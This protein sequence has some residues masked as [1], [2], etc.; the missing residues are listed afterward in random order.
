M[1][2]PPP[3]CSLKDGRAGRVLVELSLIEGWVQV[4]GVDNT[5]EGEEGDDVDDDDEPVD[6]PPATPVAAPDPLEWSLFDEDVP[7]SLTKLHAL[8]MQKDSKFLAAFYVA[9]NYTNTAVTHWDEDDRREVT[10]LMPKSAIVKANN[11]SEKWHYVVKSPGAGFILH[12]EVNHS[13]LAVDQ[14]LS[15]NYLLLL[16]LLFFFCVS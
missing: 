8:T 7:C 13:F 16:L 15:L 12:V 5:S 14:T 4:D 2:P 6:E 1:K 11:V 3:G 10:Y 9:K